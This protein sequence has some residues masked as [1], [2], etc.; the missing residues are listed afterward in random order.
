MK[1]SV[2]HETTYTYSKPVWLQPH[3]LRMQP[4]F[5][6]TVRLTS[7]ELQIEPEP[8]RLSQYLDAEG[9]SVA[10]AWF[11]GNTDRLTVISAFKVEML[12][13][14]PFDY[15]LTPAAQELPVRYSDGIEAVLAGYLARQYED[16]AVVEFAR[17]IVAEA[18]S[19]TLD[20]LMA[21]NRHIHD[22]CPRII[23]EQGSPH[24]PE[25]TLQLRTGSCR[26]VAV[27]FIEACRAVGLAA[28][29][30]SGYQKGDPDRQARRYMHAWAEVY[31]P[32]GGWRGYD[33]THGI[34]VADQHVA[35][36]ATRQSR[37]ATPIEGTF[38]GS[39]VTSK[40]EAHVKIS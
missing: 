38:Q 6:G 10:H 18:D 12:R 40:M 15:L 20:F 32:G 19:R 1:I 17:D 29:F 13:N 14:N 30:V 5:D 16:N 8:T 27:L 11:T 37:D 26:D 22:H 24:P 34:A 23:R 2:R 9:N 39:D 4:R 25:V 7:Q 31:L 33:P 36:A 21:L 35:V 28:R 3:I